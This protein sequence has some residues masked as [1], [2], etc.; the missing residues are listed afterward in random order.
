MA[1]DILK[2]SARELPDR[3]LKAAWLALDTD[4]SG[5]AP[6]RLT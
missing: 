3:R 5:E 2:L 1:R 6:R 4:S